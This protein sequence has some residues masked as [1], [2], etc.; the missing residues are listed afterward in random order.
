M[1]LT[2]VWSG[3]RFGECHWIRIVV[4][5]W[6]G[7]SFPFCDSMVSQL[8]DKPMGACCLSHWNYLT[9][10]LLSLLWDRDTWQG[11]DYISHN[12]YFSLMLR[13]PWGLEIIAKLNT[14]IWIYCCLAVLVSIEMLRKTVPCWLDKRC[15]KG[16]GGIDVVWISGVFE[17]C[18]VLVWSGNLA[19]IVFVLWT[20]DIWLP[21]WRTLSA[22]QITC[23]CDK[24]I[25]AGKVVHVY[26]QC[27]LTDFK[28][29]VSPWWLTTVQ[30]IISC[31]GQW[32]VKFLKCL[33]IVVYL[34]GDNKGLLSTVIFIASSCLFLKLMK[35]R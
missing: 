29:L 8:C 7:K 5:L 32:Q 1:V 13:T 27:L 22:D 16:S 11:G 25:I 6:K 19:V 35:W 33:L 21:D 4:L 24:Q 18:C 23:E 17:F 10:F 9:H 12:C 26:G 30:A 31:A 28:G 34:I 20:R 2:A 14:G 15:F 3:C